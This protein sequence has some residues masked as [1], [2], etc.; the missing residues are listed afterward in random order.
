MPAKRKYATEE[1][2]KDAI[3]AQRKAYEKRNPEVLKAKRLREKLKGRTTR[4]TET[5]TCKECKQDLP[6]D[7]FAEHGTGHLYVCLTCKPPRTIEQRLE[8]QRESQDRYMAK[9]QQKP[10]KRDY[11]K[12]TPRLPKVKKFEAPG[13]VFSQTEPKKNTFIFD[14]AMR[15]SM[16]EGWTLV[17]GFGEWNYGMIALI[18]FPLIM[19]LRLDGVKTYGILCDDT[20]MRYKK[21]HLAMMAAGRVWK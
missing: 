11:S 8:A 9:T 14:G 12:D 15:K 3:K 5:R 6:M 4:N 17:C 16:E 2:R 7:S 20:G 19:F 18:R 1:E 10:R 21:V 13:F